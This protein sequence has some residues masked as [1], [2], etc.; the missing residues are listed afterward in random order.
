MSDNFNFGYDFDGGVSVVSN[1][2]S[3]EDELDEEKEDR[4]DLVTVFFP[5]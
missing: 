4:G 1:F 2:N 3:D 5:P